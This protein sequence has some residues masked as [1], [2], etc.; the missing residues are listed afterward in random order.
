MRYRILVLAGLMVFL[1]ACPSFSQDEN[2]GFIQRMLDRFRKS[3]TEEVSTAPAA[4]SAVTAKTQPAA[5]AAA[6]PAA[7]TV[8]RNP[9]FAPSGSV[10]RDE[11]IDD[12]MVE[13]DNYEDD[14]TGRVRG[15]S[16]EKGANGT[17]SLL[18]KVPGGT[19]QKLSDLTDKDL[20]ALYIKVMQAA[21]VL[22]VD[23]LDQQME[24]IRVNRNITGVPVV[25]TRPQAAPAVAA[26][27]PSANPAAQSV[28][29]I[30]TTAGL[31]GPPKSP[32]APLTPSIP[33]VQV[34]PKP[35][36]KE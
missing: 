26:L 7:G 6:R 3:N 10:S 25:P 5:G 19:T 23:E 34:V 12:I 8:Q 33:K 4:K 22:R 31:S 21:A 17:F 18:Y 35:P 20:K 36:V 27:P 11:M 13:A 14:L 15:L 32:N 24:L 29:R 30:P 9:V 2:K 28:P 16:M 1:G